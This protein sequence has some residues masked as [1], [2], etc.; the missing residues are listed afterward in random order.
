[1]Q[2]YGLRSAL[3][4]SRLTA[5]WLHKVSCELEELRLSLWVGIASNVCLKLARENDV[6]ASYA[7]SVLCLEARCLPDASHCL[8]IAQYDV[9]VLSNVNVR[10]T[11]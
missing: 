2:S 10:G 11:K 6:T 8:R 9:S 1:V 7:V 5:E 4:R 3:T